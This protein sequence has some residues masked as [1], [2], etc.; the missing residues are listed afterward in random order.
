MTPES[1]RSGADEHPEGYWGVS[2]QAAPGLSIADLARTGRIP[3]STIRVTTVGKVRQLGAGFDVVST[4]GFGHHA[5]L[6][7]SSRPVTARH[8][9]AV[10]QVFGQP[11]PNPA[12]APR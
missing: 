5:T 7:I 9:L 4:R 6:V 8:A 1:V 3:H 12:R 11:I 2:V 10:S